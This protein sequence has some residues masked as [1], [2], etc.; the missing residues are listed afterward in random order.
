VRGGL[1]RQGA[2]RGRKG[3][4]TVRRAAFAAYCRPLLDWRLQHDV[5]PGR[6]AQRMHPI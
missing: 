4:R 1:E 6:S 3:I 5:H 2:A